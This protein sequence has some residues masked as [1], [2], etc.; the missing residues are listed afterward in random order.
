MPSRHHRHTSSIGSM[1]A[2]SVT[3]AGAP[4]FEMMPNP[5]FSFPRLATLPDSPRSLGGGFDMSRRPMSMQLSPPTASSSRLHKRAASTLPSFSFNSADTSGL[6]GTP[7]LTPDE[8]VSISPTRRGHKRGG[9]EYVGGDSRFG[10]ANAVSS[11]PTKTNALP[12]PVSNPIGLPAG[13]RGHAHRRSAAM[14]SHDVTSVMLPIDSDPRISISLPTTPM[15][16]PDASVSLPL[17]RNSAAHTGLEGSDTAD[18]EV[19]PS[20]RARVGFA[21]RVEYIP[22]PLSTISSET[23]SSMSTSRGHSVNNSISSMMAFSNFSQPSSR[24][25]ARDAPIPSTETESKARSQSSLEVSKRVEQEGEWLRRSPSPNMWRPLSE[26]TAPPL[27]PASAYSEPVL[28]SS[29]TH[30]K[31]HSLGNALRLD[32][33]RSEPFL[34]STIFDPSRLSAVSLG[35]STVSSGVE[36]EQATKDR[37]SSTARIATWAKSKLLRR[38]R[39]S[40]KSQD[41]SNEDLSSASNPNEAESVPGKGLVA[42][43]PEP[44]MDLDAVFASQRTVGDEQQNS[45]TFQRQ[46]WIEV[47]PTPTLHFSS[48]QQEYD[49]MSPMVDLD[50]ALG[51]MQTPPLGSNSHRRQLHSSRLT[52]DFTGPGGHYHRR[53][54]SAPVLQPFEFNRVSTPTQSSMGDVFE[55]D[56]EE[57]LAEHDMPRPM[58]S[59]STSNERIVGTGISFVEHND[60]APLPTFNWG[61]HDRSS[62][63]QR[64][65]DIDQHLTGWGTNSHRMSTPALQRRASSIME[66]TI[67]E[68]TSPVEGRIEIVSDH[69]EPRAASLTKS[70]DS[71]E[72]PTLLAQS[73]LLP[74]PDS[75]TVN[76]TPETYHTSTFSSPDF[77]NRQGSFDG[78]RLGTAASSIADNRTMSSCMSDTHGHEAPRVSMDDVPSLTSSRSTMMSAVHQSNTSRR[79]VSATE[80]NS[81][82]SSNGQGMRSSVVVEAL[83]PQK[84]GSIHSLSRL[85]DRSLRVKDAEMPMLRRPQTVEGTTTTGLKKPKKEHRLKKLMFWRSK[86]PKESAVDTRS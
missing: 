39:E 46:P 10:V 61:S 85:V 86:Q 42:Q 25:P 17:D 11:S 79:D 77:G 65:F 75:H 49:D 64:Q 82:I 43:V 54:E 73:G 2:G 38:S 26:T 76:T 71:S 78:S 21:D 35:E 30:K 6:Q 66:E 57:D 50:A 28:T 32:R 58:S 70:S 80:R 1:T 14:S 56:E 63:P 40:I 48:W 68:E 8:I 7:P 12:L 27:K 9:S 41:L 4:A 52:R 69:E 18:N 55:E 62:S 59:T 3:G 84:R 47:T 22:R 74:I 53:A 37:K 16:F 45:S 5:E 15:E 81:S 83:P 31:R 44:E 24:V 23:E 72:T 51:P 67:V 29:I 33:R 20:S 60:A 13:R 19:R 34:S 36:T